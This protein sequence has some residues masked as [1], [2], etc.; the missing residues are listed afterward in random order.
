MYSKHTGR[1]DGFEKK[2][3]RR[4]ALTAA[5]FVTALLIMLG[6]IYNPITKVGTVEYKLMT[7]VSDGKLYIIQASTNGGHAFVDKLS[8]TLTAKE[9]TSLVVGGSAEKETK[10]HFSDVRYRVSIRQCIND[11]TA[12]YFV[13]RSLF[14]RLKVGNIV[15]FEIEKS[16][17]DSIKRL[18]Q[19]EYN[20]PIDGIFDPPYVRPMT[21][22]H[23]LV[24]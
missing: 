12:T 20:Q 1:G 19:D 5:I 2:D 15:K 21:D 11:E 22:I 14:E 3:T 4:I 9:E 8:E 7:G 18:V 23:P 13:T 6:I 24:P 10:A 16:Q 17:K